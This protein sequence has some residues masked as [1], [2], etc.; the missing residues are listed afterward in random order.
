MSMADTAMPFTL[1]TGRP[2]ESSAGLAAAPLAT[3]PLAPPSPGTTP[4]A[5]PPTAPS[6][7]AAPRAAA[8]PAAAPPAAAPPAAAPPAAEPAVTALPPVPVSATLA[9]N[10]TLARKRRA[11]ETVLPLA[12]GEAGLP[13]HPMLRDAL[14]AAS[15]G[16]A[17]GPVAGLP[18]LR[19]AA[20]GYWARRGTP[21]GAASIV[22]GPGSKALLFGL[23]LAVGADVAVPQPSWVS[24][25]AQ[26]SMIGARPYFVPAPPGEGGV[27]DA[28]AL[29]RAVRAARAAGRRIGAVVVTLPDN[30]TGRLARPAS[31]RALCEVARQHD[32]IIISD[33]IYRDLVHDPDQELTS[34]VDVAPERTVVTTALSKGLALGGWRIGVARMPDSSTGRALRD[35]L[36]GIGSEIWS[37]PSLPIQQAAALAFRE[38]GPLAKRVSRSRWLHA[39]VASAVAGRFAAAGLLVPAPQAAF[40]VY[41]DFAPWRAHLHASRGLCTGPELAGHLLQ[42]YGMGVLPASAFG[43][44][45]EALRMRVATGLLYGE[46]DEQRETALMSDD[47]VA[48]P[49]I[50]AALSRID[51]ILADF[52]P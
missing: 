32:L 20:A 8:P 18:E 26:A 27:C 46:A 7:T 2:T 49:W 4:A 33:E 31:V 30:P 14:A 5:G 13:T 1:P 25:A 36:V 40:Y 29:D 19:A 23:L 52:A 38:P 16:N 6:P 28:A 34:P 42:R 45:E 10:E 48:L 39:Q 43:E 24:Y 15:G 44:G 22:C 9:A 21:T 35:R 51:D 17:Y 50:A 11:G 47:P 3:P 12:F 41:P 37:A